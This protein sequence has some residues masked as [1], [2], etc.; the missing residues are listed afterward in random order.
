MRLHGTQYMGVQAEGQEVAAP[1]EVEVV[2]QAAAVV[3][4][5]EVAVVALQVA[6][7]QELMQQEAVAEGAMVA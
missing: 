2:A 1:V 7:P 3:V 4:Q 5:E 6:A